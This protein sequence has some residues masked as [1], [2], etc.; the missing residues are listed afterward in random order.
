MGAGYAVYLPKKEALKA[1]KIAEKMGLKSWVAGR[2]EDGPRQ[3]IIKPLGIT[4]AGNSL[5][6]R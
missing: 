5:E 6:V 4:F 3:V 2:V 1:Q